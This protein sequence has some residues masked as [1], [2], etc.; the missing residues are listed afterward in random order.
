MIVEDTPQQGGQQQ[1]GAGPVVIV[2]FDRYE[3]NVLVSHDG[4]GA[5]VVEELHPT[6]ANLVGRIEHISRQGVLQTDFRLVKP[7]ALHRANG[8]YLLLDALKLLQ[9]AYAWDGLKRTPQRVAKALDFLT[10]GYSQSA[11]DV[12]RAAVF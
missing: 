5:P 12:V 9:N 6:L 8:G 11:E 3:V 1:D 2:P 10:S 4:H 7:G